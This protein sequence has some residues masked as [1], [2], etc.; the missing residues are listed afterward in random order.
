MEGGFD[1]GGKNQPPNKPVNPLRDFYGFSGIC[2]GSI[3]AAAS[4]SSFGKRFPML[5]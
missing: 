3:S 1:I 2:F 4:I 5:P